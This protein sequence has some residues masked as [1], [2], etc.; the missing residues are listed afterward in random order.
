MK[1]TVIFQPHLYSRTHDL[2]EGFAESLSQ[3]DEVILLPIYPARELP[4][5]G[6]DSGLIRDKMHHDHAHLF[7]SSEMLSWLVL[8]ETELLIMAG[9]GDIDKLIEPVK[10]IIQQQAQ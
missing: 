4:V 10:K 5:E 2:A 9:A 6:V 7:S 1:C 8:N 3:A